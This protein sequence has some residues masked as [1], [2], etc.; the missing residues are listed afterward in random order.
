MSD[1]AEVSRVRG[2]AVNKICER[3]CWVLLLGAGV[4]E[5]AAWSRGP[6]QASIWHGG[7]W[8]PWA[9]PAC[10]HCKGHVRAVEHRMLGTLLLLQPP[11]ATVTLAGTQ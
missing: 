9:D 2:A 5:Q 8:R 1:N 10:R 3:E 6:Q 4:V 7:V 11:S